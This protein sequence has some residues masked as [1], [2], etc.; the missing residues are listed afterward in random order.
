MFKSLEILENNNGFRA[1]I[2]GRLGRTAPLYA[3]RLNFGQNNSYSS[4][5]VRA[6]NMQEIG[7][8]GQNI[9][10]VIICDSSGNR[11]A[12]LPV[13]CSNSIIF[14]VSDISNTYFSAKDEDGLI[15]DDPIFPF[16]GSIS[17]ETVRYASGE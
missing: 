9:R 3:R 15:N 1:G 4:V 8:Q 10:Y 5:F 2:E 6:T 11:I 7:T 12:S 13:P 16:A 17:F 14:K